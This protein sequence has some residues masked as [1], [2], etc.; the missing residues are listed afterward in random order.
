MILIWYET[1]HGMLYDMVRGRT[2]IA[3]YDVVASQ[4][5]LSFEVCMYVY[6]YMYTCIYLSISLYI[7]VCMY[8]YI[9][10]YTYTYVCVYV[11]IYIEI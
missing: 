4:R 3:A 1:R 6:I 5:V 11:Y 9:Y 10:I 2:H 7:Y 8:I